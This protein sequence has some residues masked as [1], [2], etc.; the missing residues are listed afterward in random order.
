MGDGM[1]TGMT[2]D[3]AADPVLEEATELARLRRLLPC[4]S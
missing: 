4:E 3:A 1:E 2:G